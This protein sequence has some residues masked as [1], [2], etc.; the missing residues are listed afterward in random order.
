MSG[1][2][3][4]FVAG[5]AAFVETGTGEDDHGAANALGTGKAGRHGC[6]EGLIAIETC[7]GNGRGS[8]HGQGAAVGTGI[9]A[10][11]AGD[12]DGLVV[13]EG[14]IGQLR[15]PSSSIAPPSAVPLPGAK[16]SNTRYGL[17]VPFTEP[18][19]WLPRNVVPLMMA[20]AGR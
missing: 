11:A 20:V 5:E 15:M 19:A 17:V 9:H 4:G 8:V 12:A 10:V 2:A 1:A 7:A 6:A 14:A 18:M 16:P 13:D 3:D